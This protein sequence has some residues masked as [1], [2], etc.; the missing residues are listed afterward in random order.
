MNLNYVRYLVLGQT[1]SRS[2]TQNIS[3]STTAVFKNK[4]IKELELALKSTT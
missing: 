2:T 3:K 1:I 4:K